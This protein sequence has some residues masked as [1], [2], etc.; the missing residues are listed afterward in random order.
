[1]GR[2]SG[3]EAAEEK[4]FV[5]LGAGGMVA[6]ALVDAMENHD[7][8]YVALSEKSLDITYEGR[9]A[10]LLK[11]LNPQVIINA[12]A[13]TDIDGAES[14]RELAFEVNGAGAGNV[15]AVAAAI[16]ALVVQVSTDYVFDGTGHAP[17]SPDDETNPINVYGSSKLEGERLVRERT[18]NHLIVR[19]SLLYGSGGKNLVDTLLSPGDSNSMDVPDDRIISPTCT[20]HLAEG[21]LRL[22][23]HG[24]KGTYHLCNAGQCSLFEFASEVVRLGEGDTSVNPVT[25]GS[26]PGPAPRILNGALDCSSSYDVL[27]SPLPSWQEG[28][29]EYLKSKI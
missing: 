1:M 18:D 24:A 14:D 15:A 28:L 27:G 5:I 9:I 26:L 11:G 2:A 12:A 4:P 20:R 19:T 16:G 29:K 6:R 8:H 7:Y 17:W 23:N 10:A 21:L 3:W 13:F 22:V 25:S